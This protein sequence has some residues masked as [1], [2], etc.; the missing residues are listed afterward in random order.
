M[1]IHGRTIGYSNRVPTRYKSEPLLLKKICTVIFLSFLKGC[2][3]KHISDRA[4]LHKRIKNHFEWVTVAVTFYTRIREVFGSNI[5][6][7][8]RYDWLIF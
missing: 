5:G 1:L 7:D 4:S 2:Y 6:R 3:T 8:T